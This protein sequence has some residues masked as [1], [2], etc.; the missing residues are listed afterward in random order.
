M[1]FFGA[2]VG[3]AGS[4]S[5]YWMS[6]CVIASFCS[7]FMLDNGYS[8]TEIG[9]LIAL[10]NLLSV[11]IQPIIANIADRS[12][13]INVFQIAILTS[14][15]VALF[16][17][18]TFL[19][20]GKSAILFIAYIIMFGFQASIQPL[21]NSVAGKLAYRKIYVDYG[22]CR[23]MGS[24]G[25]SVISAILSYLVIRF[26]TYTLPWV[27]EAT[28]IFLI[29]FLLY[30]NR[31]YNSAFHELVDTYNT[32]ENNKDG[33]KPISMRDFIYGHRNFIIIMIGVLFIFYDHQIINFFQLQIFYN[34]GGNSGDMGRYYS[35]MTILELIPMAGF[36]W[37][38]RKFS[39]S[40]LLKLATL[41]LVLRAAL[42]IMAKT[43]FT[44]MLT[45]IVHPIGFPLFLLAIVKFIN[46]IMDEGEAVRGQALYVMMVTLSALIASA[47]GGFILDKLGGNTLLWI[48]LITSILGFAVI[49]PFINYAKFENRSDNK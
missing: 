26:G 31:I 35:Y 4:F 23:A 15:I 13:N 29:I 40:Q 19:M 7:V 20:K 39:S 37:I 45:L 28:I 18:V 22:I 32:V 36:T 21:L 14:L 41:G 48:C 33:E 8:N 27:G 2:N 42:M 38:N 30:L 6:Y 5:A 16:E 3:Y 1:K 24:M 43:S 17:S 25:Y 49:I 47:T 12:K 11:A 10:G 9:V 34:I 46:E 44:M